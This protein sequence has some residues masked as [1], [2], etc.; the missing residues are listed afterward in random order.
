MHVRSLQK[1]KDNSASCIQHLQIT[2]SLKREKDIRGPLQQRCSCMI[3]KGRL[4][5]F[6]NEPCCADFAEVLARH[7]KLLGELDRGGVVVCGH[8]VVPLCGRPLSLPASL[9]GLT[10]GYPRKS[11][12]PDWLPG[13]GRRTGWSLACLAS[14]VMMAH[15][16]KVLRG[17]HACRSCYSTGV[18]ETQPRPFRPGLYAWKTG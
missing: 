9:W 12:P 6:L 10:S 18:Q 8:C 1:P 11:P 15:A 13:W 4:L 7:E 14:A 16:R 2:S 5:D 3:C 17:L